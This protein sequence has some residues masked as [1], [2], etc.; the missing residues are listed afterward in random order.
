MTNV[1]LDMV[2]GTAVS[3]ASS[4]LLY[5]V[6][7][8]ILV[9]GALKPQA[10]KV[11]NVTR[12]ASCDL[13]TCLLHT[14]LRYVVHCLLSTCRGSCALV[15]AGPLPSLEGGQSTQPVATPAKECGGV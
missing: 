10:D 1:W 9:N 7:F 11:C 2:A 8:R 12:C 14:H 15:S 13:G 6:A 4:V 3:S 5:S